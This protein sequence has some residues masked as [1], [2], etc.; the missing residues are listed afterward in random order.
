ML[1]IHNN[2]FPYYG[3]S[4]ITTIQKFIHIPK[5]PKSPLPRPTSTPHPKIEQKR[6][7]PST[8]RTIQSH[9]KN[10]QKFWAY[11]SAAFT[12]T[13]LDLPP[14]SVSKNFLS[15]ITTGDRRYL[16]TGPPAGAEPPVGGPRASLIRHCLSHARFPCDDFENV[17]V[18]EVHRTRRKCKCLRSSV[19]FF[20]CLMMGFWVFFF[21]REKA[22]SLKIMWLLSRV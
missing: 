7:N 8:T 1:N 20:V 14:S 22:F 10:R 17:C 12:E 5:N 13:A 4:S 6:P 3:L 2:I 16:G 21:W 19:S 18:S 11:R 9:S 15:T